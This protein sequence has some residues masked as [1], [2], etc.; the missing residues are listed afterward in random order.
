[1]F[2]TVAGRLGGDKN[3]LWMSPLQVALRFKR[4]PS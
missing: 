3:V 4:E 1:M 2:D